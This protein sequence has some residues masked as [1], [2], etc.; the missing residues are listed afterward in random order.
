MTSR[1]VVKNAATAP[2]TPAQLKYYRKLC[3]LTRGFFVS[4]F[5]LSLIAT[6]RPAVGAFII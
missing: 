5:R 6:K 4:V 2:A 1:G 3:S